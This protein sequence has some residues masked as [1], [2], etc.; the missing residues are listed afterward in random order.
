MKTKFNP[1][2]FGIVLVFVVFI[3]GMATAVTIA[4]THREHLVSENYYE[5][6]LNFQG[7][8]ESAARAEKSGAKIAGEVSGGKILIQLPAAQ[9]AQNFSG[10]IELYR[11]SAPELDQQ[12]TLQPADDGTQTVD[13]SKLA[14]GAW[15]VRVSWNAGG[16]NYF[17]EQ[18]IKI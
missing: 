10:K 9:L 11:P 13:V 17:L 14:T 12:L 18:K 6:E 2:P 15:A 8:L 3:G 7:R 5:Q 16:E 4:C 1:W